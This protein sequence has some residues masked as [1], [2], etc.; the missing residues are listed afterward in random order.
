[1]TIIWCMVPEIPS[2][3]DKIFVI[4]GHFLP[5]YPQ[6]SKFEK[7]KKTL[8]DIIILHMCTIHDS[9]M[10][11]SFWDMERDRQNF[12]SFWTI[13]CTFIPLTTQKNQNF[14]KMKTPPGDIITLH[15]CNI[16]ENRMMYGSWDM[17]RDGQNFLPF[18]TVFCSFTPSNNP[19]NQNFEKLK[20]TSRDIIILHKCTKSNDHMLYCSLDMAH[21]RFNCYFPFWAIFYPFTSLTAQKIKI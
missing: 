12:S 5:I 8:T 13:F 15:M 7:M 9:H 21:N 3:T 11:Y 1:M 2:R 19:K 18:W 14:E 10:M 4:L 20:K 17:K 6:K 16:N